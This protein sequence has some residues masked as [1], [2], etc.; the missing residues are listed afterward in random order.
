MC[1]PFNSN[2]VLQYSLL[3]DL[4]Q[5]IFIIIHCI[6]IRV[7]SE[8]DIHSGESLRGEF[9]IGE[10]GQKSGKRNQK[11]QMRYD[12]LTILIRKTLAPIKERLGLPADDPVMSC[13]TLS[14]HV[15][16]TASAGCRD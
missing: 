14:D 16:N 7:K 4:S 10:T 2:Y 1:P 12:D 11:E 8:G 5:T 6:Y 9:T 13:Y 15:V 3:F